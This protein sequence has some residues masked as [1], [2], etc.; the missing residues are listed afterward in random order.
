[1]GRLRTMCV[2]F[3]LRP[4]RTNVG[5]NVGTNFLEENMNSWRRLLDLRAPH[6]SLEL[7]RL[8]ARLHAS[9]SSTNLKL[10]RWVRSWILSLE[11]CPCP[12]RRGSRGGEVVRW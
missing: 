3:Y 9:E 12:C 1:M 4:V 11:P 8:L 7:A 5:T 10:A 6:W 2:R